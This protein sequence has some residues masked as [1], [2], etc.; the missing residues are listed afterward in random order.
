MRAGT[1][2]WCGCAKFQHKTV[3]DQIFIIE[4]IQNCVVPEGGP[5][6]IHHLSLFLRIK[7]LAHFTHDAHDLSLPRL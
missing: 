2:R 1:P 4:M 3:T 5:T 6:L 7:I